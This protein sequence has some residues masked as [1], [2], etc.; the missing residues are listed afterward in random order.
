[1]LAFCLS[2]TPQLPGNSKVGLTHYKRGCLPLLALLL[3]S[4]SCSSLLA[5]C[6]L[7]SSLSFPSLPLSPFLCLYYLLNSP[8]YGLNKLYSILYCGVAGPSGGGDALA[9][10]RWDIPFP[11]TSPHPRRTYSIS[12]YLFINISVG[13]GELRV[14]TR[15]SQ[16]PGKWEVSRTQ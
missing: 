11:H 13:N 6:P 1:V 3:L 5:S 10:A 2:S 15:K 4:C 7:P 9:W 8:P 16:T 12:L 14:A